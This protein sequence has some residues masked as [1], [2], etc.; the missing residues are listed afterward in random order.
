MLN[1]EMPHRPKSSAERCVEIWWLFFCSGIACFWQKL[2]EPVEKVH[3][4]CIL[5]LRSL[6]LVFNTTHVRVY[7]WV[8]RL[9]QM[10]RDTGMRQEI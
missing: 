2:G 5:R 6:H 1:A 8:R 7:T 9:S 4:A 10:H 3:A